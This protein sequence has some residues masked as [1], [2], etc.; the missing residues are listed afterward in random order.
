MEKSALSVGILTLGCKVNQYESEAIAETFTAKGYR[1]V[2]PQEICDIYVINTCTVT[3]ESDRKVR[4]AVRRLIHQNP[5]AY[6]L[7]TGCLGQTDPDQLAAINGVD[8]VCGNAQKLSVVDVAEQL[9]KSGRKNGTAQTKLSP[10]DAFGF[11]QMHITHFDRTR[12]YVKIEDGCESHCTYCIIPSARGSIRSKCPEDVVEEVTRLTENGCREVV[13][14]GIETASYGKDLKNCDLAELLCRVDR[15]PNVGRIRLGSLDPSLMKQSFVDRISSLHSLAPHFH[16][17]MQ[18]GSDT[19]L[20]RMKRKYNSRMALEGMESLR[21][22]LPEARFTTDMIVG[23]PG[24]TEEEFEE[25]LAFIERAK[26]LMIHAFPYSKR[27]GTPA[28]EMK[29]QIPEPVKHQR[30]KRLTDLQASIQRRML[31][32]EIGRE[33]EVLF[34]THRNGVA[35]GHTPSFL[36]VSCPS[37][38]PIHAQTLPV[39]ITEISGSVC[40]GEILSPPQSTERK[41]VCPL[42]DRKH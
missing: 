42:T 9:V 13:L 8:F 10:P 35:T 33:T 24:E 1:V 22:A 15:I 38:T 40:T 19:V 2:P 4:Q 34:E 16:I 28:A 21:R 17:S 11:E 31:E 36:E 39:R 7:A 26:F 20:A 18:S 37:P 23:F 12:A 14:T 3:S 6:V 5:N 25:T 29:D 27:K 41:T 30:L 32:K